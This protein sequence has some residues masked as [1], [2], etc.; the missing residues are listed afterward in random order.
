[1]HHRQTDVCYV[2]PCDKLLLVLH[3]C[4]LG[5]PTEGHTLRLVLG[6]SKIGWCAFRPA[7]PTRQ[8]HRPQH[9]PDHLPGRRAVLAEA[10]ESDE[11]AGCRGIISAANL[12][13]IKG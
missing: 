9:R 5:S 3:D 11:K 12:D 4:R 2:P 8:E 6:D 7:S 1:M 10:G 13:V